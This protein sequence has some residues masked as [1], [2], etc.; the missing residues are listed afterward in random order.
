MTEEIWSL[1]PTPPADDLLMAHRWPEP[2][3]ALRDE[4][5][6]ADLRRAIAATQELRGWRDRVGAP[7]GRIVPARL[8]AAGYESTADHVARLARVEWSANG[9]EPVASVGVP[10]GTVAMLASEVVDHEAAARRAAARAG[11]AE[12]G[13]RARRGKACQPGFRGQ[14]ARRGGRRRAGQAGAPA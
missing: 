3:P 4:A 12:E 8:D 11:R 1:M 10:G 14:G 6:E 2:D 13:D 7:A 9:G 5:A